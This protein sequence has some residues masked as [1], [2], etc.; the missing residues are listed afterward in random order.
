[1]KIKYKKLK[2]DAFDP[3]K[4]YEYEIGWD[5][6]LSE[7]PVKITDSIWEYKTNIAFEIP[8]GYGGFIVP[9]SSITKTPYKLANS[10]GLIDPSYRGSVNFRFDIGFRGPDI[11]YEEFLANKYFKIG[12]RIG[13]IFFIE[14]PKIELEDANDSE[15]TDTERGDGGFGS[16]GQ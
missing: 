10:I 11:A 4:A 8:E 3:I 1:M 15:L 5:L 12:D 2:V 14:L 6:K 16:T 7:L 9:R 13:Q